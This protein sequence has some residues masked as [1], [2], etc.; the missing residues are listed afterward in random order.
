M[1]DILYLNNNLVV[2]VIFVH[3]TLALVG[4]WSG[5]EGQKGMSAFYFLDPTDFPLL[6]Q[7]T[8]VECPRCEQYYSAG[9]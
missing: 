4:Q 6:P 5:R 2:I 7:E 8:E 1:H 9:N 3:P